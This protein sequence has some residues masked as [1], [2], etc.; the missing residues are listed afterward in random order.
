[1]FIEMAKG[2]VEVVQPLMLLLGLAGG[3]CIGIVVGRVWARY[4]G[5]L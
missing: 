3:F 5:G 1:M 4:D 2:L